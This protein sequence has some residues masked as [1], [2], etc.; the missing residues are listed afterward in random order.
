MRRT[1]LVV[2]GLVVGMAAACASAQHRGGD[3]V[4]NDY[5]ASNHDRV[6][7]TPPPYPLH[8][9]DDSRRPGFNGR[10]WIGETFDQGF[11]NPRAWGDPGP[12]YF[13]ASNRHARLAFVRIG[14]QVIAVSPWVRLDE[15]SFPAHERGRSA[16]LKERGYTGGVRT[17]VNPATLRQ[18]VHAEHHEGRHALAQEPKEPATKSPEA[19]GVLKLRHPR[20][21]APIRERDVRLD[22]P[23]RFSWPDAAPVSVVTRTT[24]ATKT[25]KTLASSNQP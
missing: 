11:R 4:V 25:T 2:M 22:L 10:L 5:R 19:R 16:W 3:G 12:T 24:P 9:A 8:R 7:A 20:R 17:H 21:A 15:A 6:L 13:G 14:T 18:I 23:M 1:A